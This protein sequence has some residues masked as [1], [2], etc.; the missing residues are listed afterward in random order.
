MNKNERICL[1]GKNGT[2][3]STFL[4][5][6][7][8]KQSLDH[9]SI[10]FKKNIKIS[11]LEQNNTTNTNA[12]VY[13]FIKSRYNRKYINQDYYKKDIEHDTEITKILKHISLKKSQITSELSGGI[14][15]KTALIQV[16]I[17]KS[18][19]LLLDEPTNNLDIQ[20]VKWLEK[21]LKNFSGS[22][23]FV[24]H[25]IN[26]IQNV[27]TRIV[28][29]DRG[30]LTSWSGDYKNFKK[31]KCENNRIDEMHKKTFDNNL[32][33]EEIWIRKNVQA[34]SIRNQGRTKN[35]KLLRQEKENYQKIATFNQINI[36]QDKNY[37]GKVIFKIKNINFSINNKHVIQD[38]SS[39]IE[40]GDKLGII[41]KN[42]CGKTTIIKMLLGEILPETG[43]IYRNKNLH[44]AYFDQN[45]SF[46]NPN[47]S[48]IENINYGKES[49]KINGTE[50]HIIS[51]LKDFL[52]QPHELNVLVKTLSGG[53]YSRLLLARLFLKPSNVLILDEPTNDLDLDSLNVLEKTIINYQGTVIITSHDQNFIKNTAKKF[54]CFAD[55]AL[56]NTH[57]SY[58]NSIKNEK[59]IIKKINKKDKK[60]KYRISIDANYKKTRQQNLSNTL[61]EITKLEL[62]IQKLQKIINQP[63]FFKKEPQETMIILKKLKYKEQALKTKILYWENLEST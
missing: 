44:I 22:I 13:D 1:I 11:Y 26:F 35:L 17:E 61:N 25:N 34:R 24:S 59:N 60:N 4:K 20:T 46:L 50:Q 21:T 48:I 29:L 12:S 43:T 63:N 9:G 27:S 15:R 55:N 23:L 2:G 39:V 3:K 8:Q 57:I 52:F 33:K 47:K 62:C 6:I 51:Y 19:I 41:G 5:I 28:D 7:N 30:K 10:T 49:I 58:D 45:K 42:G 31:L 36:N 18:D 16:L 32:K 37:L 54:W 53:Q 38:F 56:I 14:L 40:N